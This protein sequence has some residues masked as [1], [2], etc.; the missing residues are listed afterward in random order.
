M[1]YKVLYEKTSPT[2]LFAIV[3]IPGI[4]SML[5]IVTLPDY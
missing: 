2:K 5:G 4:I 1:D 3:A